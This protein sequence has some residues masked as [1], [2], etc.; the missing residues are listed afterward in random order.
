M[1]Q[2]RERGWPQERFHSGTLSFFIFSLSVSSFVIIVFS[3][4]AV[5]FLFFF[6][7]QQVVF[8]SDTS[9]QVCTF[10]HRNT[11]GF[12]GQRFEYF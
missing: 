8:V 5:A 9:L 12:S 11:R 6:N 7:V 4:P 3:L 10:S 1:Q 2:S